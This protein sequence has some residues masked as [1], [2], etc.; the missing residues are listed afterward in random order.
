MEPTP[1]IRAVVGFGRKSD[2]DVSQRGHFVMDE[3]PNFPKPPVKISDLKVALEEFDVAVARAVTDGGRK[4]FAQK[5]RCRQIV[6]VMLRQ[7][8]HYVEAACKGKWDIFVSSGFEA[9]RGRG[10]TAHCPQPSIIK[11]VQGNSGELV[12]YVTPLY[13]KAVHYEIGYGEL[14]P[15]RLQPDIWRTEILH[16]A[17]RPFR[18]MGLK[19]AS[20]YS[21]RVR[22]Y[23]KTGEYT[24]WSS[25]VS[26]MCT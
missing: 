15:D 9:V 12:A 26:R 13:R 14:P 23:G 25:S 1:V 6:I 5:R 8:G 18:L 7:L 22:A 3:N 24:D 21:F 19:P 2:P 11:V 16:Q 17:K 4:A 10:S 20:I